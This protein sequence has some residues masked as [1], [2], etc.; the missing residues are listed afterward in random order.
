MIITFVLFKY[1]YSQSN[2]N[3]E[4][5]L[6][7]QYTSNFVKKLHTS[8]NYKDYRGESINIAVIDSGVNKDHKD[9]SSN[10]KTGYNFIDNIDTTEDLNG[11]GTQVV[12]II[13]SIDNTIGLAGIAPKAQIYPLKILD[14]KGRSKV[15]KV[16]EALDWC[17][18]NN[19]DLINL[20]FSTNILNSELFEKINEVSDSG[21]IV[22]ASY[23]NLNN[24]YDYPA[25]YNNVIGVKATKAKKIIVNN[26]IVYAYGN[27]V[28][29]TNNNGEYIQVSGNSFATAHV[30]GVVAL[31]IEKYRE[32]GESVN[33]S[34]IRNELKTIFN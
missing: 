25:M 31:I 16:I 11:H 34:A 18:E 32:E 28:V 29:T 6:N 13:S 33:I 5:L 24:T 10:I 19:I 30:T 15:N 21:I 27:K 14:D 9:F 8:N 20:S 1:L 22:V 2:I 7:K 4:N 17:I 3:I 12:G 26:D 23:S